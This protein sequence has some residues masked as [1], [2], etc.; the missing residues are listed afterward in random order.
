MDHFVINARPQP[1]N[2]KPYNITLNA[3]NSSIPTI[4]LNGRSFFNITNLYLSASNPSALKENQTYI[5]P[6]SSS[7][8]LSSI[9]VGFNAFEVTNYAKVISNKIITLQI[10]N[11][12]NSSGYFDI[13]V[14]N[15]SGYGVLSNDSR[16]PILST[17]PGAANIQNPSISGIHVKIS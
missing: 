13:I 2:V 7:L 14:Q 5:N 4:I 10:P 1:F 16:V 3:Y 8:K 17:Y 12:F 11:I 6:F 15:E 9:Y